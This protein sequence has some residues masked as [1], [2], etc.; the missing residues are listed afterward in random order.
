MFWGI[1]EQGSAWWE[2]EWVITI[3]QLIKLI[4]ELSRNVSL[5][6]GGH[7][8]VDDLRLGHLWSREVHYIIPWPSPSFLAFRLTFLK[9]KHRARHDSVVRWQARLKCMARADPRVASPA[10]WS[11]DHSESS[12]PGLTIETV[13]TMARCS[14]ILLDVSQILRYAARL[15]TPGFLGSTVMCSFHKKTNIIV[16]LRA[17]TYISLWTT[18]GAFFTSGDFLSILSVRYY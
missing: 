14:L 5:W 13:W 15:G 17:K 3:W 16:L 12:T 8:R 2:L 7:I 1:V 6:E 10:C 11:P 4:F 18:F 9:L